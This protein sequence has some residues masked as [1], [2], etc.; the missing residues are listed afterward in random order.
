MVALSFLLWGAGINHLGYN[1]WW[2]APTR[3]MF[4]SVPGPSGS[5]QAYRRCAQLDGRE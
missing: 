2:H 5:L 1:R 3:A 4:A